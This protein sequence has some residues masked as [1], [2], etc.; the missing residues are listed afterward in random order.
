[1]H[2]DAIRKWF[3]VHICLY[4]CS[5]LILCATCF[6][7]HLL[8]YLLTYT[9]SKDFP[10][11][12]NRG[13]LSIFVHKPENRNYGNVLDCNYLILSLLNI[14]WKTRLKYQLVL[15]CGNRI[16]F[17]F[18]KPRATSLGLSLL[19]NYSA[20]KMERVISRAAKN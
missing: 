17:N 12:T 4:S 6:W 9:F 11:L 16:K 3:M 13:K 1:M 15:S 7:C 18:F 8:T 5:L 2:C 20:P 10:P 19:Q 14:L